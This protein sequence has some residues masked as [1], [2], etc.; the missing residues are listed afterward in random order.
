VLGRAGLACRGSSSGTAQLLGRA[1]SPVSGPGRWT[2]GHMAITLMQVHDALWPRPARVSVVHRTG[3]AQREQRDERAAGRTQTLRHG[4]RDSGGEKWPAAAASIGMGGA[5]FSD[6]FSPSASSSA[7]TT[8]SPIHSCLPPYTCTLHCLG[9]IKQ[10]KNTSRR[11][12]CGERSM[13]DCS[14]N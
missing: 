9:S 14:M 3:V 7:A 10:V 13:I 6:F 4:C 12:V 1:K 2:S 11:S 8:C 5:A